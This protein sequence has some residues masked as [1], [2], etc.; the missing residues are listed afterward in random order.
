MTDR[1]RPKLEFSGLVEKIQSIH[2][3]LKRS[4][5]RSVNTMLT[6]RNWLI[7]YYITNYEMQGADRAQYG[8]RLMDSISLELQRLKVPRSAKRELQ[9][10]C[11]FYRTYPQILRSL[12]AL[13]KNLQIV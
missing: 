8:E 6:I 5:L 2:H 13:L 10:F 1:N 9:R 3:E 12:N 4:A 11:Q 7:G